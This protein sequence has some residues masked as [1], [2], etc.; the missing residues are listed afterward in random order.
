MN[1]SF[2]LF[3]S[4]SCTADWKHE[5]HYYY[6]DVYVRYELLAEE[7]E[8]LKKFVE[9]NITKNNTTIADD[10]KVYKKTHYP[11]FHMRGQDIKI[12]SIR[13]TKGNKV[14]WKM[15]QTKENI[16]FAIQYCFDRGFIPAKDFKLIKTFFKR[17]KIVIDW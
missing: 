16:R 7:Y 9:E 2:T 12:K 8:L 11:V 5:R 6:K 13:K 10:L 4:P 1:I 15:E 3:N 17:H 14:N